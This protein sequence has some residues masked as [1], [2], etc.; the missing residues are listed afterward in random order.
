MSP[1]GGSVYR[2]VD[3]GLDPCAAGQPP[4]LEGVVSARQL[5]AGSLLCHR[6]RWGSGL[7][8][9][10]MSQQKHRT[11]SLSESQWKASSAEETDEL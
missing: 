8:P 9:E 10:K 11:Q 3:Q 1:L 6:G 7:S 4:G 2:L 5:A